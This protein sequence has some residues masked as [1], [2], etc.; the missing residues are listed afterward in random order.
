MSKKLMPAAGYLRK[1]TAGEGKE[2]KERQEK[3]IPTQKAEIEKLAKAEGYKIV[4]WYADPGI[5]GWKR[6]VKRPDFTRMIAEAQQLR[7]IQAIVCDDIDRFSRADMDEVQADVFA[8]KQA[9]VQYIIT[10]AQGV[11]DLGSH[12][13]DFGKVVKFMADVWGSN[14]FSRKLSRRIARARRD[15]AREGKRSG[16]SAPYGLANDGKGG[17]KFGKRSEVKI[18]RRIFDEFVKQLSSM[19]AIASRLNADKIPAPRGGVWHVA[20][21]RDLLMQPAYAGEFTYNRKQSGQFHILN[22][23]GEVVEATPE[24]RKNHWKLN[25]AAVI[26]K[27][28]AHKPLVD[29]TVFNAAQKRLASFSLKG[30]RRPR[31]NGYP[32]AGI[33]ICDH[34][35]KPMYGCHQKGRNYR[36][37]RCST[38]GKS[39]MG[40]CG[41]YEIREERILPFVLQLLGEELE[42]FDPLMVNPPDELL[43][44]NRDEKRAELQEERDALA[45]RIEQAEENLLYATDPRTRKNF[46]VRVC[47]LR[48]ELDQLDAQ[49]N[50]PTTRRGFT[51]DE[52]EGL[53]T[54]WNRFHED[55]LSMPIPDGRA[56][57][58]WICFQRPMHDSDAWERHIAVRPRQVNEILHMLGAEVRLRWNT[59]HVTLA[60]GKTQNRYT[61]CRGRFRLS[62]KAGKIPRPVLSCSA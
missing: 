20:T 57:P 16:G 18:V 48:A 24:T 29:R 30:N 21:V 32:L 33:L 5:S 14:Q 41:A 52:I 27:P 26:S 35:G 19:N 61:L 55:A 46:D 17:L 6:G 1:S 15:A 49:L 58:W 7:D 11:Y 43:P 9:G 13:T 51:D 40:T 23:S 45:K 28:K 56:D 4:R 25:D 54:F 39:G 60:N 38:P 3:S 36:V 42:N 31:E 47:R 8:L 44:S 34:C 22:E 10:A 62:Q 12:G 37:Y 2:G 50:T 59:Q 53:N